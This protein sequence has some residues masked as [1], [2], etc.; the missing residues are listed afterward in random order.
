MP[1]KGKEFE[2]L[3]KQLEGINY[4]DYKIESPYYITDPE[5]KEKRELDIGIVLKDG[6]GRPYIIDVECRN[7]KNSEDI[8]WI[9]ELIGR[10][11]R[12]GI[13]III[14]VTS[15]KFTKPAIIAA[16][17]NGIL[18]R[19]ISQLNST[20]EKLTQSLI[21]KIVSYDHNLVA[22]DVNTDPA[23]TSFDM[24]SVKFSNAIGENIDINNLESS[25]TAGDEFQALLSKIEPNEGKIVECSIEK[26]QFYLMNIEDKYLITN[27]KFSIKV[28]KHINYLI[29]CSKTNNIQIS[30]NKQETVSTLENYTN[31]SMVTAWITYNKIGRG[32]LMLDI[33]NGNY[34][35]S[36]LNIQVKVINKEFVINEI[37]VTKKELL[38]AGTTIK[39]FDKGI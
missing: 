5:T 30:P 29:F 8:K 6:T 38:A 31:G 2:L 22:I 19:Q 9:E 28:K 36:N 32:K 14:A 17:S 1:R 18:L 39:I 15:S 3:V 7:R 26:N 4:P 27:A 37:G 16:E 34:H 33:S 12:L 11:N 20:V 10:K 25:I 21:I 24:K 35:G 13:D 23:V